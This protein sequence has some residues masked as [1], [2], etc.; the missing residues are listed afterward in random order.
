M[1]VVVVARG[2]CTSYVGL[3]ISTARPEIPFKLSKHHSGRKY[4]TPPESLGREG[5]WAP[6]KKLIPRRIRMPPCFTNKMLSFLLLL[7]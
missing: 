1:R 6:G 4:G 7:A 5:M 2:L 3:T